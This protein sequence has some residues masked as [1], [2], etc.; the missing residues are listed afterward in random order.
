MLSA[1]LGKL[2]QCLM[3]HVPESSGVFHLQITLWENEYQIFQE[4]FVTT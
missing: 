2:K 4:I 3:N 1:A